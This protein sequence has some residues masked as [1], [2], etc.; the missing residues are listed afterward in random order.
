MA[1]NRFNAMVIVLGVSVLGM[2]QA[3]NVDGGTLHR[4]PNAQTSDVGGSA[5]ASDAAAAARRALSLRDLQVFTIDGMDYRRAP[6][7]TCETPMNLQR[8]SSKGP[9]PDG[10]GRDPPGPTPPSTDYMAAYNGVLG[11]DLSFRK[12]TG[13]RAQT[14]CELHWQAPDSDEAERRIAAQGFD[15]E[16]ASDPAQLLTMAA[17]GDT[18]HLRILLSRPPSNWRS[19]DY[20]GLDAFD[21]A[22]IA[23]AA[24]GRSASVKMLLPH[25]PK[26]RRSRPSD[27]ERA[28]DRAL[29]AT[30]QTSEP[31]PEADRI[32]T[33]RLLLQAGAR[34][35]FVHDAIS[36]SLLGAAINH[37]PE[38]AGKLTLARMLLKAGADPN[39]VPCHRVQSAYAE[40]TVYG[41]QPPLYWALQDEALFD[42]LVKA[43][44]R[45]T[46]RCPGDGRL[47]LAATAIQRIA[48]T[49][50]GYDVLRRTGI[51]VLALG[52]RVGPSFPIPEMYNLDVRSASIVVAAMAYEGKR[53]LVL[54]Q[55][56]AR[57]SD[58]PRP[59][60]PELRAALTRWSSCSHGSPVLLADR[61]ELCDG[62]RGG[63]AQ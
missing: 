43:G 4:G 55:Y 15:V 6:G 58:Q 21:R 49:G 63:A 5:K 28:V 27:P 61:A 24:R 47:S 12:A 9:T 36:V 23:A 56:Q 17:R 16:C 62:P 60:S 37:Q 29:L 31:I 35:A 20:R 45:P 46:P 33:T 34:T 59:T 30:L 40:E 2:A 25:L 51:K 50:T 53:E 19:K 18:V 57:A 22:L 14:A 41:E 54:Q 32:G 44:A 39:G 3:P 42:L 11:A 38:G 1:A 48:G 8:L 52:G 13:C 26:A 7:L 10:E